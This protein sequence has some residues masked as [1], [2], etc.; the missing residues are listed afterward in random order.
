MDHMLISHNK[1][2]CYQYKYHDINCSVQFEFWYD[3]NSRLEWWFVRYCHEQF[4]DVKEHQLEKKSIE[5]FD[6][7]RFSL[8]CWF[9]I[10]AQV[11]CVIKFTLAICDGPVACLSIDGRYVFAFLHIGRVALVAFRAIFFKGLTLFS[12]PKPSTVV[13][14][15]FWEI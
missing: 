2:F 12:V 1:F 6:A 7:K 13:A 11:G 3:F 4:T 15:I 5:W 8:L 10:F 9:H 14:E